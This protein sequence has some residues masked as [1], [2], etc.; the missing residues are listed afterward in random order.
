MSNYQIKSLDYYIKKH[1]KEKGTCIHQR[2]VKKKA[3]Y[4]SQPYKRLTK[5]W[6]KWRYGEEEGERRFELHVSKSVQSLENFIDRYGEVEGP[7]KY[8]ECMDKKD[9]GSSAAYARLQKSEDQRSERYGRAAK[10][11]KEARKNFTKEKKKEIADRTNKTKM[12]RY[13][14]VGS[15]DITK[16]K[17]GE[18]AWLEYKRKIFPTIPGKASK[19]S[20]QVFS[21]LLEYLKKNNIRYY[22]GEEGNKEY[23]IYSEVY[24]QGFLYDLTIFSKHEKIILEYDGE[25]FHPL[26]EEF[27]TNPKRRL[28]FGK[29]VEEQYQIDMRKK[30]VAISSGFKFYK[31]RSDDQ[32]DTKNSII[33]EI[34]KCLDQQKN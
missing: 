33:E 27:K 34:I 9:T 30:I 5:E 31:I 20:L 21:K 1:G 32:E 3:K 6:F 28:F 2:E 11:I 18:D 10:K 17:H 25:N 29:A 23:R 22:V 4:D 14:C 16:Y 7:K 12:E 24:E 13:G 26:E 15:L 19:E 8:K